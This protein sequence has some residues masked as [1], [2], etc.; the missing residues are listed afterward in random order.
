MAIQPVSGLDQVLQ[1]AAPARAMAKPANSPEPVPV[2]TPPP[3]KPSAEQVQEAVREIRRVIEPVAQNLQF[4][5]DD[6]SGRTIVK[7]VDGSTKE[8]VRQI[9]S[10]EVLAIAHALDRLKGVLLKQKA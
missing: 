4:S 8:V 9:P 5:V 6:E 7:I 3:T 2:S 1:T 10:E